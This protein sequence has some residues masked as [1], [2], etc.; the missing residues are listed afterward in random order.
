VR[1]RGINGE[2]PHRVKILTTPRRLLCHYLACGLWRRIFC[3]RFDLLSKFFDLLSSTDGVWEETLLPFI[4]HLMPVLP[5]DHTVCRE[6]CTCTG[7][8]IQLE[9]RWSAHLLFVGLS[10]YVVRP[11]LKFVLHGQCDAKPVVTIVTFPASEYH[12]SSPIPNQHPC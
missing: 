12:L 11:W 6:I 7:C 10:P 2:R 4:I 8:H 3:R 5:H 1:R 9:H